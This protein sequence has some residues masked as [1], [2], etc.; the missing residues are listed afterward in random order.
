MITNTTVRN[1]EAIKLTQKRV[2]TPINIFKLNI[3]YME[4]KLT[5]YRFFFF[6]FNCEETVIHTKLH[7]LARI[8]RIEVNYIF[9]KKK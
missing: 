5:P 2:I 1:I 7:A 3:K 9:K 6:K 4:L 8:Y